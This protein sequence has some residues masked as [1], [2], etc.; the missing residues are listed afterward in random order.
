MPFPLFRNLILGH[1]QFILSHKQYKRILLTGQLSLVT[2][3]ICLSYLII[4][5]TLQVRHAWPYQLGCSILA[6]SSFLL[7]RAGKFTAAKLLLGFSVNLTVF[8][9]SIN[10]PLEV[11]L[12]MYFIVG[13]LGALIAFGFEEQVKAIL[14][15][16][17]STGLF[18]LSLIIHADLFHTKP[19]HKAIFS[20]MS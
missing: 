1:D 6:F 13:N 2:C 8:I 11:G 5:T 10:E 17:F 19:I 16:V 18:L 4:D 12:Y 9:F 20:L 14:F 15:V 3:L 7:N